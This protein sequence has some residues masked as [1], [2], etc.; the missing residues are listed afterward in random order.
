MSLK[1]HFTPN[2]NDYIQ[3]SRLMAIKTP[4][5]VVLAVLTIV[6]MVG[7]SIGLIFQLFTD[8]ITQN[9]AMISL[10]VGAFYVVYYF[11][12]TPAQLTKTIKKNEALQMEREFSFSEAEVDLKV[13]NQTSRLFWDH[14]LHVLKGRTMYILVY[15]E[16]K[17]IYPFLPKRALTEPGSEEAFLALLEEH[18][19]LVK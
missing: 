15:E 7:S 18:N 4:L 8:S 16:E 5:F 9:V 14:F 2:K 10:A 17:K 1:V 11:F 19:I 13:G 6:I 12:L 3:A